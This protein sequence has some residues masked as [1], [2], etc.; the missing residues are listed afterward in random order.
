MAGSILKAP[1][2]SKVFTQQVYVRDILPEMQ[3]QQFPFRYLFQ[4]VYAMFI[5]FAC[6]TL[7]LTGEQ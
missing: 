7:E 2:I 4:W 6:I 1:G 5:E 3:Y